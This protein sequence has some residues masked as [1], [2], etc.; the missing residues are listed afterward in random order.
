MAYRIALCDD[1]PQALS[2]LSALAREWGKA[3][4]R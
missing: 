2:L 1:Q 4:G 3:K